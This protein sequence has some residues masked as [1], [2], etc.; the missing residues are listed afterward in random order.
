MRERMKKA[1]VMCKH[2]SKLL[3]QDAPVWTRQRLSRPSLEE[4]EKSRLTARLPSHVYVTP[5]RRE[6]KMR[7]EEARRMARILEPSWKKSMQVVKPDQNNKNDNMSSCQIEFDST[8]VENASLKCSIDDDTVESDR[9]ESSWP[10][11]SFEST[12]KEPKILDRAVSSEQAVAYLVNQTSLTKSLPPKMKPLEGT[13]STKAGKRSSED[14]WVLE[15]SNCDD[16]KSQ[17]NPA[18][19]NDISAPY[20]IANAPSQKKV[21]NIVHEERME[22]INS[23]AHFLEA[24]EAAGEELLGAGRA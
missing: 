12:I 10:K 1:K 19:E 16:E 4:E 23:V 24:K 18:F 6:E 7:Q 11:T 22:D 3:A 21:K 8:A 5:V 9:D 20:L 2:E 17:R 15:Q 14:F 13:I